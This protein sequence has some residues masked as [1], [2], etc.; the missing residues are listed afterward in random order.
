MEVDG[1]VVQIDYKSGRHYI[2]LKVKEKMKI[3]YLN[4]S[5]RGG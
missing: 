1:D 5:R 3:K 2:E 4:W